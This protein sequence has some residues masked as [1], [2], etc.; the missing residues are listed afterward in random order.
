MNRQTLQRFESNDYYSYLNLDSSASVSD[1]K[2]NYKQLALQWHPDKHSGA[3]KSKAT[4]I[5]QKIVEAHETL[6]DA[7]TRSKYDNIWSHRHRGRSRVVPDWAKSAGRAK[8]RNASMDSC[9]SLY[10]RGA[11]VE[12]SSVERSAN[13]P[14]PSPQRSPAA[15]SKASAATPQPQQ[16]S[17]QR[18]PLSPIFLAPRRQQQKTPSPPRQTQRTR[19]HHHHQARRQEHLHLGLSHLVV[20]HHPLPQRHLRL[21]PDL[22]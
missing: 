11:S 21:P 16:S 7:N 12:R 14:M 8:S 10:G 22:R 2:K 4:D 5:F 1:I 17:Q 15:Q 19:D 6:T 20:W 18:R 3:E 13:V 9:S